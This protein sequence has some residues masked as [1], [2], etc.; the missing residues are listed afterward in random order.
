MLPWLARYKAKLLS[1]ERL[2]KQQKEELHKLRTL[3]FKAPE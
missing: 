3:T 1:N 2:L